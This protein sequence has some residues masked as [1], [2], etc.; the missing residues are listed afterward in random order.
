MGGRSSRHQVLLEE[1]AE[2]REDI[3]EGGTSSRVV[4][5]EVPSGWGATTVL[6][7]FA[8]TAPYP[9]G[10]VLISL[11]AGEL[12]LAGQAA[13]AK[14]LGDALLAPLARL[15]LT[16]PGPSRLTRLF[17][18]NTPA[19]KVGLAFGVTGLFMSGM[20]AQVALLLA[21]YGA[22]AAQNIWDASP[23]GQ[24]GVLAR[25]ARAVAA[26]SAQV[27]VVVLVDDA[28][29][30]DGALA[31]VMVDNLVSRVDGHV[32]VVAVVRPG[33]ELARTLRAQDRYDLIGRVVSAEIDPDMSAASRAALALELCPTLP[34]V[35]AERIGQRTTSFAQVFW[36]ADE[37][38][39]TDLTAGDGSVIDIVDTA[40][41]AATPPSVPSAEARILAWAG[42]VLTVRQITQALKIVSEHGEVTDDPDVIRAGGLVRLRDPVSAVVRNQVRFVA[43]QDKPNLA[44]VILR[45]AVRIA[46]DADATLMERT[47]ARL[48]AHRVRGH[49]SPSNEVTDQLTKVQ[50]LLIRGLEQLGDLHAAYQVAQAALKE[51]SDRPHSTEQQTELLKARL[52]LDHTQPQSDDPLMQ[53]AVSLATSS[54][55][56][57]GPETRVWAA[58]YLLRRPGSHQSALSLVDQLIID[59]G[60]YPGRDP[61]ANQW[62]L[63]LAFHAG[64]VGYPAAAQQLLAPVINGGTADHQN[65]AQ[66][67]LRALDGPRADI[68]LQLII[69]EAELQATPEAADDDRLR[70]HNALALDYHK[71]GGYQNAL[72]H[73]TEELRYRLR[74]QNSEHPDILTARYYIAYWTG[75]CGDIQGALRLS[76]ELLP[77]MVRALGPDHPEVLSTRS[78]IGSWTGQGGDG[79]QALQLFR[80]LLP[81]MVRVLGLDDSSVLG[82]RLNIAY[83][84]GEC[85]DAQGALQLFRELLPDMVRVLGPDHPDVLMNRGHIAR[86]TGECGDA[87]GALQLFREL[88]PDRIRVLG[89]DHPDVL[90]NRGHIARWTGECGDLQRALQLWRELLPDMVQV[91]GPD[92]PNVM[93]IR[94]HVARW[95]GE[96]GD[97]QRALQL[98]R[99]LLPDMVQVLGPDHP[100]VMDIRRN[101]ARWTAGSDRNEENKSTP[102]T[103]D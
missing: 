87:R 84:T 68:R 45:E 63:L 96:C 49:L 33:G 34:E 97:L 92:H 50:C 26:L 82:A 24:Q 43:D 53:Q 72:R 98:W 29:R 73:G 83:F 27:P 15:R 36:V 40:I 77:D 61:A 101:I 44:Q 23:A 16:P 30:F 3:G 41:D 93:D 17:D 46:R 21:P 47:V 67:V 94:G 18:L 1:L 5:V 8:A 89:P 10:P 37:R 86:R 54:G 42:G 79:P 32:L 64:Q 95:T 38:K 81:D 60:T 2:W 12:L 57:L 56:L 85:G 14:T 20:S 99:E 102:D 88:L 59:L 7:E 62:R 55:A 58:V 66:A 51:L 65:A 25:A 74:L 78:S 31:A 13:D 103:E 75:Q 39:L 100:N 52:R 28:D 71:L 22:T 80:E 19:G 9:D 35:A 90:M 48:A 6:R 11:G 69:L 70:I 4:L 76:R 91:L